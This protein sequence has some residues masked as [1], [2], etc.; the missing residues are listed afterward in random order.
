MRTSYKFLRSLW[1]F[2]GPV[3]GI[4]SL[5]FLVDFSIGD[6][7][8]LYKFLSPHILTL[9]PFLILLTGLFVFFSYVEFRHK[10][11][12]LTVL[13]TDIA[14]TLETPN[15]DRARLVR[16]QKIR[17]N[18]D[19][20][21][22]YHRVLKTNGRILK[23]NI[24]CHINHCPENQ[25]NCHFDGDE[26]QWD[27]THRFPEIPRKLYMLGLNTVTRTEDVL[28]LGGFTNNEEFYDMAIPNRYLHRTMTVRIFFHPER[29][30]NFNQCKA[31]CISQNGIV[32][33]DLDPVPEVAG[34]AGGVKLDI[35]GNPGDR[36]R[37]SWEY[38]PTRQ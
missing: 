10:N 26:Q 16:T 4:I 6:V 30:P 38:P 36:F 32:D 21:T 5:G 31:I 23:E 12:P 13:H 37:I 27:F 7:V 28:I 15:G 19:G 18:R 8:L 25:Q 9:K 1:P 35:S 34:A 17:V 22:G 14:L 33:V 11:T 3:F 24:Q 29:A 20:V 2:V